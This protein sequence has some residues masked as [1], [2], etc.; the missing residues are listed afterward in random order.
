MSFGKKFVKNSLYGV[1]EFAWPILL[2]IAV[3]PFIVRQLGI[4][5]YGILSIVSVTLG[6]FAIFDLG[7]GLAAVRDIAEHYEKKDYIEINR[8]LSSILLTYLVIGTFGALVIVFAADFLT[9]QVINIPAQYLEVAKFAFYVAA[10]GFLFNMIIGVLG[11]IP[12]AIQR[13]DVSTKI[14]IVF[15]TLTS[16]LMVLILYLG[17]GLKEVVIL[18][19]G[20]SIV[21]GIV[22][23]IVAKRLIP[24]IKI[25]FKF[26][27][28]IFF[29]LFKFGGFFLI[30]G[31]SG[32]VL[33]QLDKLLIG[34]LIS[35]S[36]V[37]FYVIPSS[38]TQ[39]IQGLITSSVNILFPVTSALHGT[40]QI[41]KLQKVYRS[42]VKVVLVIATSIAVP[43]FIFAGQFLLYWLGP[44]FAR[45]STTVMMFLVPTYLILGI[46]SVPWSICLGV[47]KSNINALFSVLVAVLNVL[48]IFVLYKPFGLNGVAAAY[49]LSVIF[50]NPVAINYIERKILKLS[51]YEFWSIYYKI[52]L[53]AVIQGTISLMFIPLAN[54]F[55][56]TILLMGIT[57]LI[58]P[59]LYTL[60]KMPS[61]EERKLFSF[62]V[63]KF[64]GQ[65]NDTSL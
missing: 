56:T 13:Y 29:R 20:I 9:T 64:I 61:E 12:K 42:V 65:K 49:F 48:L 50:I 2:S 54:S 25:R 30:T 6:F 8:V 44:D 1:L 51:G 27:K 15:G 53:L 43:V 34:S 32:M 33:L 36:L 28:D 63:N 62:L 57:A 3:T 23:I 40:G 47:G 16:L 59:V 17:Y 38:I 52:L 22:Y 31:I 55:L 14:S 45:E 46:T 18:N 21:T 60:F 26:Y 41:E 10:F 5:A 11:S 58:L 19:L 24:Q 37:T 4:D 7:L 35:V 39:R